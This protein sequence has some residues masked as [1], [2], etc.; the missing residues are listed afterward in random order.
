MPCRAQK[1][2]RAACDPWGSLWA[3]ETQGEFPRAGDE[4][5]AGHQGCGGPEEAWAP[6]K[7]PA[8]DRQDG[9]RRSGTG[10]CTFLKG[11]ESA[12]SPWP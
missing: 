5:A 1:V 2:R 3:E 12:P 7:Q 6:R 8:P 4:R 9:A 11:S 10:E